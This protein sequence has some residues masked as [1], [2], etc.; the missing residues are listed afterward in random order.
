MCPLTNNWMQRRTNHRFH[1][2]SCPFLFIDTRME[3]NTGQSSMQDTFYIKKIFRFNLHVLPFCI[4]FFSWI[5][6]KRVHSLTLWYRGFYDV[7]YSRA[8]S[9]NFRRHFVNVKLPRYTIGV[10]YTIYKYKW[11][12]SEL[13]KW[14][15]IFPICI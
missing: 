10:P 6:A 11:R 15:H 1:T 12:K 5:E 2:P 14:Q 4:S 9:T 13:L 7:V 8:I 3:N